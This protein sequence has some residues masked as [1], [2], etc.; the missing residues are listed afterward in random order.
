MAEALVSI[1]LQRLADVIQKQI[2]EEVNLVRG[3]KKEVQY[4]SSE[5][6]TIRNVLEDAER[7][8]YKEKSIQ[9]WLKKL[10]DISCDADDVLDEWNFAVLKL[11]VEGSEDFRLPRMK[12][13]PFTSCSCLSFEKV[14]TRRDIAKKIK[15]LKERLDIIVKEK[16]QYDFIVNQPVAPQE[17]TRVQS[18]SLI[19]L[20]EIQGREVDKDV[21][22]SKLMLDV[23][24]Q[25][26]SG[27]HVISIVG[28]GGIGKTTL[29]QL[30]YND[31]H[32]VNY[33]ES[34][35]WVCVSDVFDEVRIVKGIVEIVKGSSP[36][37]NE[38]EA[39]LKCLTD[40]ISRKKFLLI[41][42]DV[43]TEDYTK[44]EPLKKALNSGAPGSKILVTTRSER[45]AR[46]MGT[47]EI[48][49]LGQLSDI[50]CWVLMKRIAFYG[51]SN[52]D[53]E[54]LQ[55]IGKEIANKCKGL[56]LAAKVLGSLLRF[57]DTKE[58][59]ESILNSELWQ[60]EE[61]EVELFPHLFLS[62]NELSPAMKRCFSYSAIFPKDTIID[63]ENLI[64][65]WMAL[66]YLTSTG[67]TNDLELRG[68]EYFNN[69]RMR[70]FFQDFKEY[71]DRVYCKMHDI[72]HDFAKFLRK[73]TSHNFNARVEARTNRS[74][75]AYDPSLVSEVKVYRSLFCQQE[76]PGELFDL[77][78]CLRVLSLCK[79][80]L[81]DIQ[82]GI[83]NL[84]HLRY[85]DMSGNKLTTQVP[86][87]IC[88]LFNLQ[89]LYLNNCG[90]KEVPWEIGHLINLRHL[91]LGSNGK[92]KELPETIC[93]LHDLQT[94]K[95]VS[96]GSLSRLPEGIERLVNLKHLPNDH[97]NDLCQ[98]PQGLE[99]LT[100][101]QTLRLFAVG[102]G[103]SKLGYLKK[104]D[105]L[106]GYLELRIRLHGKEDVD[107]ARKAEL[108]NK[109][110]IRGL[111]IW[112]F[113]EISRTKKRESI[114]KEA[115]EALQPHPN[116]RSLTILDYQGTKFPGWFSS[117]LNHLRVLEIQECNFISTLPCLGKLPELEE[118][119]VWNT[120]ELKF[121]GRE[122]LGI[123]GDMDGSTPSSGVVIRFPKLKELRF[124]CCPSWK[125]WEDI[126]AE[127][128]ANAAFFI[129]PCLREL[130]ID[131]C[132]LTQL[133]HRLLRKASLL[134]RLTVWD[135]LHLSECYETKEE[136][137]GLKS[138]SHIPHIE[139]SYSE[140][141]VV[142]RSYETPLPV[143]YG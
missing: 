125:E 85:L 92:I 139:M 135:S 72:V 47:V 79:H 52:G 103:W 80:G 121:L 71:N 1:A 6:G 42:D 130:K 78:A 9:D 75:K 5:L 82:R 66:G 27:P 67:S 28:T 55:E 70:S 38:L 108:R 87:A 65:M 30:I 56:P 51:R 128:E 15:G 14:A 77:L 18:T 64:R 24:G 19:D 110:H 106:S 76:L 90:L 3:V 59:W 84:I 94:L 102:R 35:I 143:F 34:R 81:E 73:T 127:E 44:W 69:L 96:C 132:G 68:K 8:R 37:L 12:V 91:D 99:Q 48:H 49:R 104:L 10:E 45:V 109:T 63:V 140:S 131:F 111:K 25:Q 33:F 136:G 119:S 141:R 126:T 89:T 112:F 36:N 39:L 100:G 74:F 41:L 142:P 40:S 16:N 17:T 20:S 50:D 54:E 57:K 123:A 95:L 107:E 46:M 26:E 114:R 29:A 134:E 11:Q 2:Q 86:R 98:M 60:L 113:N 58:E 13:C 22:V 61:V 21:L 105:Q 88:K 31:D 101:L 118:L 124:R 7:R 23:F 122:F 115:F 138:L 97:T 137:A 120:R 83:E 116:L 93:N 4:L 117:S 53:Y 133:P 32:L 62:Y 129:M 43:W